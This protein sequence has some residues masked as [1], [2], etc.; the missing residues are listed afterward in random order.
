MIPIADAMIHDAH[1]FDKGCGRIGWLAPGGCRRNADSS[2]GV[3][4]ET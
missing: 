4:I 3:L 1:A 2:L